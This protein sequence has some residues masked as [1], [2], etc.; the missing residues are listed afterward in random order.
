M[1]LNC[2]LL[3]FIW[4]FGKEKQYPRTSYLIIYIFNKPLACI[5]F[6]FEVLQRKILFK[7]VA[8]GFENSHAYIFTL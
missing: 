3:G 4:T 5:Y 8:V 1:G 2:H 7:W 6:Y